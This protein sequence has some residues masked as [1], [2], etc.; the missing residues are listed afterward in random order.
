LNDGT[1]EIF[2]MFCHEKHPKGWN[3]VQLLGCSSLLRP[4]LFSTK[5]RRMPFCSHGITCFGTNVPKMKKIPAYGS[6]FT[7]G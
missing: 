1:F 6:R 7:H 3:G 2:I 5:V 4:F